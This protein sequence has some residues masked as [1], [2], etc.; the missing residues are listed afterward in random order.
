[1]DLLSTMLSALRVHGSLIGDFSLAGEW[2]IGHPQ[3]SG[4]C[5]HLIVDGVCKVITSGGMVHD[6]GAGDVV[7]FPH[8]NAHNLATDQAEPVTPVLD[9][10]RRDGH[11]IWIPERRYERTIH[12]Y[13]DG[14]GGAKAH[15][16]DVIFGLHDAR[17]HPLMAALPDILV[18]RREAL[19]LGQWIGAI[20]D[21]IKRESDKAGPGHAA[22][23]GLI[24]DLLF[25]EVVRAFLAP[26]R[27]QPD[28]RSQAMS[29][30][31]AAKALGAIHGN[32]SAAWTVSSLA[33]ICCMSR[34]S[35]ARDFTRSLGR[36]PIAYLTDWRMH[37]AACD[38]AA[39]V[40]VAIVAGRI[41]YASGGAF[42]R[43]FKRNYKV[44]PARYR[45]DARRAT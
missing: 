24:A 19:G 17:N 31:R 40:S 27:D 11:S 5:L 9:V 25:V 39:G 43:A 37:L 20:T 16:V 13:V 26:P 30:Q 45:Q 21:F 44:S 3:I 33:K 10:L 42:T 29:H 36:G 2:N 8:G 7:V 15:V 32:P 4:V 6:L 22:M 18:A 1:M 12:R 14:G 34:A 28:G 41:G 35:F 38:L 23:T